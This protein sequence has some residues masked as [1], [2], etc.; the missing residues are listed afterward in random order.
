M[1][2]AKPTILLTGAAGYIGSHSALA[3]LAQGCSVVGVD[4]HCNSSVRV[5]DRVR[6]LAD[7]HLPGSSSRLVHVALDVRDEGALGALLDSH[8]RMRVFILRRSR[9][10][11]SLL[12]SRWC[13]CI[14][15]WVGCWRC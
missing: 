1:N 9:R 2:S 4:N 8:L 13:I 12:R 11:V 7:V 14:T 6:R 3:L 10:W 5:V 15:T